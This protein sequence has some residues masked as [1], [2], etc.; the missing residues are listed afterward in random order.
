MTELFSIPIIVAIVMAIAGIIFNAGS[1]H[2]KNKT[3]IKEQE[4]AIAD[5]KKSQEIKHVNL[6]TGVVAL[7]GKL[8]KYARG[9]E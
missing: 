7:R 6:T 5:V 1:K 8:L 4:G 2:Q 9:E 3:T